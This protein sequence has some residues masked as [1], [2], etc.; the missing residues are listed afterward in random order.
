MAHT[1]KQFAFVST[2]GMY[3]MADR[4][5]AHIK[6][7]FGITVEHIRI[8]EKYFASKE[9]IESATA[10][11]RNM[12]IF[13]FHALQF[14]DPANALMTML[15]TNDMLKRASVEHISLVV[16]Y[17]TFCRQDRK[18]KERVPITAKLVADLIECKSSVRQLIT[19]DTHVDQIQGFYDC[20]VDNLM[21][22]PLFARHFMKIYAGHMDEVLVL[23]PDVGGAVRARRLAKMINA[24]IGI[25]EKRRNDEGVEHLSYNG[26]SPEGRPCI[27][28]DDIIDTGG[29]IIGVA[30]DLQAKGAAS[31]D[32]CGTHGLFSGGAEKRFVGSGIKVHVTNSVPRDSAYYE[33]NSSWLQ[34]VSV[35]ELLAEAVY[36]ANL[37]GGSISKLNR[38]NR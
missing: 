26:P 18:D 12:R 28:I 38:F 4:V 22:A 1:V 10:T 36:E 27:L 19:M 24:P 2:P 33:Q 31:V 35:D 15:I 7:Q 6:N 21:A 14:P 8:I 16:P 17:L 20:A 32:V 34:C 23:T 29:T 37:V 11:V 30:E 25:Y 9:M 3:E 5:A 13:F